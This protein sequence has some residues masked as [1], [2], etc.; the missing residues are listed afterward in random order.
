MRLVIGTAG[1]VDHGKTSLVK[2]LTGVDLDR[3]PEEKERGIT[4]ALGF[5]PL[6]LPS[7][8]VAGLVDVPGHERLVRTMVAGASGMDAVMLCVSAVE[9]VMPQTREHLAILELLGVKTGVLVLTMSDLVE[10]D[11]LA[12]CEEELREQVRGTFLADAPAVA[13]SAVTR[14]GLDRLVAQLDAIVPPPK[15]ADAPFRLPVDRAFARRG[16]GTVVTGTAWGGRLA[17]GAEIEIHPGTRRARVRGMQVHGAAVAEAEAGARTALNLSGVELEE[18]GRGSWVCAPGA[19]PDAHVV[20][21]R[22]HHLPGAPEYL[23]EAKLVVLHGTREVDARVVPLDADGLYAGRSCLV[24]IR[25]AEPLPCLPGDR[26]V[27]RRASPATTVGGGTVLDPWAPVARKKA[28]PEAVATL[29]RL[30]AGDTTAWLDRAGPAGLP[31][32]EARAR[33]VAGGVRLGERRLGEAGAEKLAGALRDA[34]ARFHR[35]SPLSPGANRKALREGALL[36]LD[37]R[38]WQAL[39]DAEAAAG[40]IVLE[41]GRVR[42]P[43]WSVALAPDETDWRAKA[44]ASLAAAGLEGGAELPEHPRRDALAFY[45]RDRGEIE[46][47]GD[48]WY[49][50]ETLAGLAGRVRA[51]FVERPELDPAAF[52][53]LTGLTRRTAI[54]L[55]EWLD[56]RGVTKRRGDVRV[57][58]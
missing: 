13:T 50:A 14:E 3:L 51:F 31:E 21:A 41:G 4:I 24:Q 45:L 19:V 54:P 33:G 27:V 55:L 10:P 44:L 38:S 6:P 1:H 29:R 49:A 26:F 11:L 28:A 36:A 22:Y 12:L 42:A 43:G 58:A 2:A 40:R 8:R 15:P 39:L 34:L 46:Q 7:G 17:D 52:K 53:D 16:F 32:E 57:K 20:D 18:V 25:A 35:E 37:E 9:G 56:S 48:R 23:E 47:V 5:T 30:E